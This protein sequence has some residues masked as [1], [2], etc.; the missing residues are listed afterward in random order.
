MTREKLAET[1]R[2]KQRAAC[3]ALGVSQVLFLGYDDGQLQPTLGLRRDLVRAIRQVKPEAIIT[4]DP[5][6]L[7]I[8]DEYI[9]H[10]D[11]RAAAQAA[12][13][14]ATL[15]TDEYP[16]GLYGRS[17]KWNEPSAATSDAAPCA[18]LWGYSE[19]LVDNLQARCGRAFD[20]AEGRG[21]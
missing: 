3:A 13:Y 19:T 7:F 17:L 16:G 10:L 11:H 6:T 8:S 1:R 21:G 20:L 9:N 5:T 12:V 2:A 14:I 4:W 15:L 18:R